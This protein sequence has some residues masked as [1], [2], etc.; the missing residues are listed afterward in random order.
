MPQIA[1]ATRVRCHTSTW[2]EAMSKSNHMKEGLNG[3]TNKLLGLLIS[4][5]VG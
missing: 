5:T 3:T 2:L 1:K 4:D